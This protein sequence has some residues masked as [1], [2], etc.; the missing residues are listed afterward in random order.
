M[1]RVF[2]I[3]DGAILGSTLVAGLT[4]KAVMLPWNT[5]RWH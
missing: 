1:A 3:V 4:T 5:V 2:R